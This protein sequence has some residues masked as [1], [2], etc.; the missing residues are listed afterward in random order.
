MTSYIIRRVLWTIPVL[1]LTIMLTVLLV[2]ALPGKPFSNPKLSETTRQTLIERYGYDDSVFEQYTKILR[3]LPTFDFGISTQAQGET[4]R[5]LIGAFLPDTL[6]L[7]FSAFVLAA[8]LGSVAGV[9]SAL[10]SG[11]AVDTGLLLVTT[12]FFAVPSFVTSIYWITYLPFDWTDLR[13]VPGWAIGVPVA[14]LLVGLVWPLGQGPTWLRRAPIVLGVLGL[15]IAVGFAGSGGAG[16]GGR[17]GPIVVLA[18]SIMP[19][20]T[21]LLRATMIEVLQ[22][23]YVTTARA[24]GL[25]WG[26]TVVRHVVR[27]SLIPVVTNAGPLFAFVLTGSFIVERIFNVRGI[28]RLFVTSFNPSGNQGRDV[29]VIMALTVLVSIIIV[30]ANTIVDI[31]VARLDPRIAGD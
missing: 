12:L 4:A 25:P 28:A 18:L 24:K 11:R 7:G 27:N 13:G 20:F 9:L 10:W 22:S 29:A 8:L 17:V 23:E 30:L 2:R 16:W 5:S 6:L 15:A 19:Y 26:R 14:L 1:M 31:V 3:G 21:R